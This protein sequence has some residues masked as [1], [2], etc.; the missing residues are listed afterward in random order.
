LVERWDGTRWSVVAP[1][2]AGSSVLFSIATTPNG[3][4]VAGRVGDGQSEPQP[5]AWLRSGDRW[6]DLSLPVPG[7]AWLNAI[8]TDA[9][10]TL[11][12]VGTAFPQNAT[13]SG[14]VVRGCP[15]A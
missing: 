2:D 12:G 8:G 9:A 4:V 15:G 10:G 13:L 11:W 1:P 14:L 6:L 5:L 7:A 3:I